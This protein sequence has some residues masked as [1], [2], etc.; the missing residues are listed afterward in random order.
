[1]FTYK[2]DNHFERSGLKFTVPAEAVYEDF[3][4]EYSVTSPVMGSYAGVHHLQ[5]QYT[6]LHTFCNL[7]IKTDNLPK[8]LESKAVIVSVSSGNKFA[9]K[10]GTFENGWIT[11]KIR[12]FGNYTVTVD[13]EPPVIRVI[14]IFPNKKVK[15]QSSIL[16]KISDNLSGIKTYRGTL[17]GK[18]ILMDYDEKNRLL[19]Y[20][21]DEMMKPGKNLFKLTVT[22]AVGNSSRYEATLV[23]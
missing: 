2:S 14:N 20:S 10:G 6:P 8:N 11:T 15:K 12:D 9:S 4:F 3:P 16:V 23:K 1:L 13:T 22:D 19:A 21:F 7:S 5:N 18:W 17:N